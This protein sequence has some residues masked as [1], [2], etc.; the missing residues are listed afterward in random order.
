LAA[1]D[2]TADLVSADFSVETV[3]LVSTASKTNAQRT[4]YPTAP[5]R[6]VA[7]MGAEDNAV[8]A[9][10]VKFV[11]MLV[12]VC[13]HAFPSVMER[14]VVPMDAGENVGSALK[15]K[16]ALIANASVSVFR[17][18]PVRTAGM[19]DAAENVESVQRIKPATTAN[20][21]VDVFQT[22]MAKVV[23]A[24]G[25]EETAVHAAKAKA[26][27]RVSVKAANP[28]ASTA[29]VVVT[30]VVETA[31]HAGLAYNA[32]RDFAL[33]PTDAFRA[34]PAGHAETIAVAEVVEPV[35]LLWCVMR[36]HTPVS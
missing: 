17:T 24:M 34:V 36:I 25:A 29:R 9:A 2:S 20:A 7:L 35:P 32:I 5:V 18:V 26:V 6:S 11:I 30:D 27:S 12:S 1:K 14:T 21:A 28:I 8:Y 4:A 19:T 22:V 10:P 15:V 3:P 23:E 13:L 33:M 16:H 31:A